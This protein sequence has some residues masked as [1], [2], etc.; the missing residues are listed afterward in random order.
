MNHLKIRAMALLMFV[1]LSF[2]YS[3]AQTDQG[4]FTSENIATAAVPASV[5][6]SQESYFPGIPVNQWKK[7]T[8]VAKNG[9]TFVQYEAWYTHQK[10][11]LAKAHYGEDGKGQSVTIYYGAPGTPKSVKDGVSKL[12]PG[13]KLVSSTYVRILSSGKEGYNVRVQKSTQKVEVWVDTN[14]NEVSEEYFGEALKDLW[15]LN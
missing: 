7:N 14:G 4:K 5:K 3:F 6:A 15:G 11:Q 8:L 2:S 1:S 13:F 10:K 12:Y 9:Q